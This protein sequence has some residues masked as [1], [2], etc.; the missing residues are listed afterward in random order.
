MGSW[1][2]SSSAIASSRSRVK[3]GRKRLFFGRADGG[4]VVDG[5]LI[6]AL[7]GEG[8]GSLVIT[9]AAVVVVGTGGDEEVEGFGVLRAGSLA[10]IGAAPGGGVEGVERMGISAVVEKQANGGDAGVVGGPGED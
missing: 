8:E 3:R 7:A 2:A 10:A 4:E 5:G 6:L 9:G 1:L